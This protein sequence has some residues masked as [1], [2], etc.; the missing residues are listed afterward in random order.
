MT[1]PCTELW[2]LSTEGG[3]DPCIDSREESENVTDSCTELRGELR[4]EV[5]GDPCTGTL[6][7]LENVTDSCT[8]LRAELNAEDRGYPDTDDREELESGTDLRM[9][10]Q[11]ELVVGSWVDPSNDTWRVLSGVGSTWN[12]PREELGTEGGANPCTGRSGVLLGVRG[13]GG[14]DTLRKPGIKGWMDPCT[15]SRRVLLDVEGSG[16]DTRGL[17]VSRLD[18][19]AA[20]SE[21]LD[22]VA[23]SGIQSVRP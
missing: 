18:L 15:D 22:W 9:G 5:R 11:G 23:A 10:T 19:G 17:S 21:V 3:G 7:K 12:E 6:G 1:D 20:P 8:E 13:V 16:T 4:T 14:T 2:E